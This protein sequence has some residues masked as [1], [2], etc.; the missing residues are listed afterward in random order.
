MT[1]T[2]HKPLNR[3]WLGCYCT[4]VVPSI[5]R[6]GSTSAWREYLSK[7]R[8]ASSCQSKTIWIRFSTG[9]PKRAVSSRVVLE[10]ASTY[11]AY[12]ARRR[13]CVAGVRQVD[14]S[15]SCEELMPQL[16][17]S[18]AV[19]RRDGPQR[20]CYLTS[21]TPM[22]SSSS[23]VKPS[24]NAKRE[25]FVPPASIWTSTESTLILSNIRTLIIRYA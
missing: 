5:V 15:A 1:R 9:T 14:P 8:R 23:G 17:Q 25:C 2:R 12:G 19:V 7:L 11:L 10:R 22:Y 18:R 21:I 24:K 13:R 16:G 3:S 6:F 4:N 20:W